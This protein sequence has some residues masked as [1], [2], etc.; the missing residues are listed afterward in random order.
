MSENQ[1]QP[2]LPLNSTYGNAT[3]SGRDAARIFA[4]AAIVPVLM[5]VAAACATF[6]ST[7]YHV[8][9]AAWVAVTVVGTSS[10]ISASVAIQV[11]AKAVNSAP[12]PDRN[13]HQGTAVEAAATTGDDNPRS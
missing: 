4:A 6:A 10:V 9:I 11:M 1:P 2:S 7:E 3:G 8:L 12:E 13:M 5:A